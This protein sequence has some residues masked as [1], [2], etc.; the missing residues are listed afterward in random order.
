MQ[1]CK[2]KQFVFV[3]G[4]LIS[5]LVSPI[6]GCTCPH[7]L[8]QAEASEQVQSQS[9]HSDEINHSH[10]VKE[11]ASHSHENRGKAPHAHN[12]N[13]KGSHGEKVK[14]PQAQPESAQGG[15]HQAN[16]S[17][18]DDAVCL[19]F[20]EQECCCIQPAP[21][22]FVKAD[23]FKFSNLVVAI[24]PASLM[25][26]EIAPLFVSVNLTPFI[27]PFYLSDSFYNI[28]PGRAPPRL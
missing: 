12:N 22:A 6:L 18:T 9:L 21:Q 10:E 24:L 26:T 8:Y 15:D 25:N 27:K 3:I 7:D 20:S 5:L 19:S 17:A 28:S 13:E 16:E 1:I 11:K 2:I 4:C 14:T 23:K